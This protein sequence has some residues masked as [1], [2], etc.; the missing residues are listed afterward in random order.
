[1]EHW[2]VVRP[3]LYT[4]Y[5]AHSADWPR[6]NNTTNEGRCRGRAK[7]AKLLTASSHLKKKTQPD[8]NMVSQYTEAHI[9]LQVTTHGTEVNH[10]QY[11]CP[12]FWVIFMLLVLK[13]IGLESI[14]RAC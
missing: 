7:G 8:V 10:V 13:N 9:R 6:H 4:G 3:D 11:P 1:M 14:F 2:T 5:V 12:L